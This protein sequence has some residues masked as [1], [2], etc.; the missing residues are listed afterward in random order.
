MCSELFR[1][2]TFTFFALNRSF[3]KFNKRL[4]DRDC[5][6]FRS[7]GLLFTNV[8]LDGAPAVHRVE[9]VSGTT[10]P[11][12]ELKLTPPGSR[13]PQRRVLCSVR[14]RKI[15]CLIGISKDEPKLRPQDVRR[16][17]KA[18]GIYLESERDRRS[19]ED[20]RGSSP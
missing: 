19:E 9:K 1:C 16:A 7:V 20:E 6:R 5:V 11:I 15:I 4:S 10:H 3:E 13:G 8:L 17:D 18:A 2:N 12:Y 14:D